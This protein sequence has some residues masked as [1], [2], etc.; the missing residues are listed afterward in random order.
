VLNTL[1]KKLEN[2][3][4]SDVVFNQYQDKL[5]LNNLII[6]LEALLIFNNGALLVGE[7]PGYRGCKLTGIPFTSGIIIKKSQ[8]QIFKAIGSQIKLKQL[9]SEN[10]A[11]IFWEVMSNDAVMPIL[12]NAFPYHP[13]KFNNQETN[14]KPTALEIGE[15]KLYLKEVYELFKPRRLF[16]LGRVSQ[17]VLMDTFP[18]KEVRYIRHPSHGGKKEF[19]QGMLEVY[20]D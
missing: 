19:I 11:S 7:A 2:R 14:R 13:H 1:L 5:I 9:V 16:A 17:A 6:F 8:H 20:A 12:W 3:V 18:G 15:G 10:T 4:S